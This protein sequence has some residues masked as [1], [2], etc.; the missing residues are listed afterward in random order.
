VVRFALRHLMPLVTKATADAGVSLDDVSAVAVTAG[1]GLIGALLVGVAAAQALAW[2]RGLPLYAVNHL[3]GHIVSAYLNREGGSTPMPKRFLALV[4]SGGHSS[5]YDVRPG[6]ASPVAMLNRTRDDAAGEVFDK[7]AKFAGFP[8]PG[9]P[10]VEKAAREATTTRFSFPIARFRDGSFDFSFSG[11]KS[12]AIR[13]ARS[14]GLEGAASRGVSAV[15]A[16]YCRG[17]QT[18]IVEQ[19][20][21]RLGGIWNALAGQGDR[22]ARTDPY[23]GRMKTVK[24]LLAK[25]QVNAALVE[26]LTWW[27]AEPGDVVALVALGEALEAAGEYPLA[28]RVYGSIIDLYPQRADLRRFAGQRLEALGKHGQALAADSYAQ[29]ARQRPDHPGSHRLLAFALLRLGH[30]DAA[31]EAILEGLKGRYRQGSFAGVHDVMRHDASL[32]AAALVA[33]QPQVR[34]TVEAKLAAY[35]V[36]ISQRPS[37]R[38]GLYWETDANDVDFHITDGRK[39][40]AYY[41]QLDLPTGG[42]LFADVTTGYGPECFAIPGKPT[43]YP[44]RLQI[45]YYARGPMGYGMGKLEAIEHDGKGNLAFKQI[46]YLV[47][48]DGAFVDLGTVK[49]SLF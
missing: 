29:A 35:D 27:T 6:T 14:E 45:H 28:A 13:I 49:G 15:L 8:Y 46:P 20:L 41:Q 22:P 9:G 17:F 7:V 31:L 25:K 4:V 34:A 12:S 21:D 38:F 16:D 39:N 48:N 26:A 10:H 30:F 1:P 19:L 47:M 3:E 32:I 33:K 11:I 36:P 40:H 18:A 42:R 24:D 44:Y 37:L 5:I 2:G 23:T 43:A